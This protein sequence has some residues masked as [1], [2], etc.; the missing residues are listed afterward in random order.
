MKNI[1][2][3][4][5]RKVLII[6]TAVSILFACNT[7]N[8]NT[9]V[10]VKKIVDNDKDIVVLFT[11]DVHCGVEDNIGYTGLA[12][13][14]NN[15]KKQDVYTALVDAGDFAQG[16]PIGSLSKGKNTTAI[17]NKMGYD[18][19]VPG[20][21]EFDYGMQE[22][23]NI[24]AELN[25]IICTC[26]LTD[27][28]T[29]E[30]MLHPY[31]IITFGNK[32]V[33]FVGA[34]T[35][36]A[37]TTSMPINFQDENGNYKYTFCE[38][39]TGDA[40]INSIQKSVD[41]ARNEGADYIILVGHLGMKGTPERWNTE[42]VLKKTNNID[43]CIDGHSHEVYI[44]KIPNKD[45]KEVTYAQTGTKLENIGKLT[46]TKNG[47]FNC[48][49]ISKVEPLEDG[50]EVN[51]KGNAID[52]STKD[53]IENIKLQYEEMLKEVILKDN[54]FQLLARDPV[55][56]AKIAR[57]R[58]TNLGDLCADAYRIMVGADIGI[59]NGGAVRS[60][61]NK[62]D[63]TYND[64]LSVAPFSNQ[65]CSIKATGQMI[66]DALEW[67]ARKC[68]EELGGFLQVSGL[69][70]TIDT[71]IPTSCVADDKENFLRVDGERR[72]KEVKVGEKD[73]NPNE[74]YTVACQDFLLINGGD[75]FNMFKGCE[76]VRD[77]IMLDNELLVAYI[78]KYGTDKYS[79]PNGEGRIKIIIE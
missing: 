54:K 52:K 18:F 24:C 41:A 12:Y 35:P 75:G 76:V 43:F 48:E 6:T 34:T 25:N 23:K 78:K 37:L 1:L 15:L 32:K 2:V 49:M 65:A 55:T 64:C 71:T 39:E 33:A 67:G 11:N 46:I 21:H 9:T 20:N 47:S 56:D 3:K 68:P 77:G 22:F 36:M 42:T 70:Y 57:S 13:Y 19:V 44:Y 79:N 14:Y 62:G 27:L 50:V 4:I 31:K 63:I 26:N 29:N 60:D 66:L 61:I 30:L 16:A 17:I 10:E 69:T 72:V 5:C 73:I 28:S 45:G 58:E 38:D 51:K 53:F 7:V 74:Y 8:K 40:F 59:T